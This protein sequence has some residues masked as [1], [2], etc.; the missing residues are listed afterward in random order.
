MING[1]TSFNFFFVLP[2][3]FQTLDNFKLFDIQPFI[4][5]VETENPEIIRYYIL[6]RM[7]FEECASMTDP[8][9]CVKNK[10][11][12]VFKNVISYLHGNE[13]NFS[14]P[15]VV[16]G[17]WKSRVLYREIIKDIKPF[18]REDPRFKF[19]DLIMSKLP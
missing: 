2:K 7:N 3:K 8:T 15:K 6:E 13:K 16:E 1:V 5:I 17:D 18:V 11:L 10:N 4:R 19:L 14:E 9:L 12:R